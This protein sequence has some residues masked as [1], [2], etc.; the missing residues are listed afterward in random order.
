MVT[1]FSLHSK[2]VSNALNALVTSINSR[3]QSVLTVM[4]VNHRSASKRAENPELLVFETQLI[5]T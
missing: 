4:N 1:S 3:T 5:S 2:L